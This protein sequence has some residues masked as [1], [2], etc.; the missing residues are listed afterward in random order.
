MDDLEKDYQYRSKISKQGKGNW[1]KV[2][3]AKWKYLANIM[4]CV[5]LIFSV[6]ANVSGHHNFWGGETYF[7]MH[8]KR[9]H[10]IE[11]SLYDVDRIP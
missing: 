9:R 10:F 1:K 8:S 6:V 11:Q 3:I 7:F 2:Q 5:F 4:S